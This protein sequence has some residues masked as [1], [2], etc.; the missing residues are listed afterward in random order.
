M[1]KIPGHQLLVTRKG[2]TIVTRLITADIFEFRLPSSILYLVEKWMDQECF[3]LRDEIFALLG[4]LWN[5]LWKIKALPLVRIR[6]DYTE[7]VEQVYAEV[8]S[9]PASYH[10]GTERRIR[11]CLLLLLSLAYVSLI[12]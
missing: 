5:P 7:T 2:D 10:K 8:V 12:L 4:I 1:S 11:F 3:D 6:A 9:L